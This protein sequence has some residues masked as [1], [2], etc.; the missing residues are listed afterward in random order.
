MSIVQMIGVYLQIS[1]AKSGFQVCTS[2]ALLLLLAG[3][4]DNIFSYYKDLT[5][6]ADKDDV[7]DAFKALKK[8]L[9]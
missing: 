1:S 7:R 8:S 2:F 9:Q 3:C 6:K 5:H 4:S